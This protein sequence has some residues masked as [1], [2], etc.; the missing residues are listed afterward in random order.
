VLRAVVRLLSDASAVHACF[1]YLRESDAT[2][3]RL[4]LRAASTPYSNLVGQIAMDKGEGLAWW[5]VDRREPAFIREHALADPRVK[6]FPELEEEQFQSLVC[7]PIMGKS[8]TPIGVISLHTEAPREFTD[9]DAEFLVSSAALVA[10]AIENARLYDETRRRIGELEHLTELGETIARAESLQELL[11]A[12]ASR[13]ADLLRA[14]R[15]HVYLLDAG[16][17]ELS[18]RASAPSAGAARESIGLSEL[19]PELGRGGRQSRLAVPLVAN[20]ELLGL[21]V[22]EGSAEVELGRAVAN[23]TAVAIKKIDLIERLTEKN[24]IRDFFEELARP[25][26]G[27][28]LDGRAARLGCDLDTRHVVLVASPR[29]P[30]SSARSPA[31]PRAPSST[32]ATTRHAPSCASLRAAK[33]GCS[34]SCVVS[35]ASSSPSS[36]SASRTRAR[37]RPRSRRASRRPGTRSSVRACS[38]PSPA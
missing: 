33:S 37:E 15:C 35:T 1:V 25:H 26:A 18:L 27:G 34:S 22:A 23:Q 20:E 12:V 6:Y 13:A 7:V 32:G 38:R 4:V 11:P 19:G 30:S 8:G 17:E 16:T 31:S 2:G 14:E 36:P 3:E 10:G 28:E 29:A 5:A 21:L 24:L 9:A